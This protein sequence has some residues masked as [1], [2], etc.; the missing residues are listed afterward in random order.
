MMWRILKLGAISLSTWE[1]NYVAT[2]LRFDGAFGCA[3]ATCIVYCFF[4]IVRC[5]STIKIIEISHILNLV[6]I[7]IKPLKKQYSSCVRSFLQ[8]IFKY[9]FYRMNR[10]VL[11]LFPVLYTSLLRINGCWFTHTLL[12]YCRNLKPRMLE[13]M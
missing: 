8:K 4:I 9:T 7:L 6:V 13:G 3:F 1:Q 10:V 12:S 5:T 2:G 11:I